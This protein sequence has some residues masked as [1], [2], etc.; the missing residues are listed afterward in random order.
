MNY[1]LSIIIFAALYL[2]FTPS[3]AKA[4][5]EMDF[6]EFMGMMSETITDEQLDEL[7]YQVPW[8]IKVLGYAYGDF[9][10]DGKEDI[11][12]SIREKGKT[13]KKTVDVYFFEN[14]N[15]KTYKLIKLKNYKWYEITLEVAFLVKEGKCFVTNR[16]DNNW[17]FTGFKIQGE[18]L[19]QA[20]NEIFPIEFETAGN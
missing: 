14:V 17:Y 5:D 19:V 8:D 2:L 4:Q 20:G 12:L 16:D 13:S 9:S 1:R 10:G 6:E 18:K 3:T 7:S 15:D 11:V